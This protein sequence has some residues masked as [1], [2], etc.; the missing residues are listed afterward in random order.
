M[1]TRRA[2]SMLAGAGLSS[3]CVSRAHAAPNAA[4]VEAAKREGRVV[5]YS[6]YI[7]P[8]SH[9][10]IAT[11]FEKAYGIKIEYLTARGG[12][13][14]E[15]ARIEQTA[16][17]FLG[18]VQHTASSVAAMTISV[19]KIIDP[20]G[21]L[22]N[23][24]RLKPDF[25]SRAD[26][27]Q[28]PIFTINYGMLVNTS[29]VKPADEPKSWMDL[30]D[31]KWK[32]KILYDDPRTAGGGRVMFHMTMDKFGRSYHEK[33][34]ALEPVF[35]RDYGEAAR[36]VARGEFAIYVP[37]ILSEYARL[38]GLPVKMVIPQE[39]VT[40]GSYSVS[41]LRNAP[42]PNAARLLCDFYLTDEV[43]EIYADTGHGIVI[44]DLKAKLSA[45]V[46]ELADVKPLVA[47]D[48]TRIDEFLA[49]AKE[50]YK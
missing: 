29:M 1:L 16:G 3:L 11:A 18:D 49:L 20:H 28:T 39:G 19:D 30:L 24:K 37:L 23:A 10:R 35:S 13:L 42:H 27:M 17:R 26:D 44:S 36:R 45:E 40:Y 50:I 48:F 43:Q 32:G 46:A 15:R 22:P 41:V 47:E 7:S 5:V 31:P 9:G 21:G 12:E 34:A 14:R 4:L 8:I 33:L 2:F 6:A 38:K 25:A